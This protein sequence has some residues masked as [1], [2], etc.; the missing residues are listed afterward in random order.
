MFQAHFLLDSE[1]FTFTSSYNGN[2]WFQI[3]WKPC[4]GRM[5]LQQLHKYQ[6]GHVLSHSMERDWYKNVS[7]ITRNISNI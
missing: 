1:G 4:V 3:K 6:Q 7:M 5:V 2:Q